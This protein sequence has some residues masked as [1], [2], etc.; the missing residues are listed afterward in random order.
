[1]EVEILD[2]P[3]MFVQDEG[4]G[5]KK[6]PVPEGMVKAASLSEEQAATI[7][8]L[9]VKLEKS[10]G[11]PQDFEWAIENGNCSHTYCND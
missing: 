1:M 10:L 11:R 8:Q 6:V 4:G 2:K 3:E 7:G 9:L 5:V